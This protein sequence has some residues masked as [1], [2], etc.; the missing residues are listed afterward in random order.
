MTKRSRCLRTSSVNGRGFR[1]T[2]RDETRSS[3]QIGGH[4]SLLDPTVRAL[5]HYTLYVPLREEVPTPE[6]KNWSLS[7]PERDDLGVHG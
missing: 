7:G 3:N 6:S 5:H 2:P 1:F 4:T